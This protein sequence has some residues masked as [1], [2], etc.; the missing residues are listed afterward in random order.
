MGVTGNQN[1]LGTSVLDDLKHLYAFM[2]GVTLNVHVFSFS[3]LV[4]E[5]K[6]PPLSLS[7]MICFPSLCNVHP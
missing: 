7:V 1:S 2:N 6:Q 4:P 5:T 3:I